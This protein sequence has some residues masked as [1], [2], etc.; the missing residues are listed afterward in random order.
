MSSFCLPVAFTKSQLQEMG[1]ATVYEYKGLKVEAGKDTEVQFTEHDMNGTEDFTTTAGMPYIVKFTS[2]GTFSAT[3]S[4][5]MSLSGTAGKSSDG[6]FN[7]NYGYITLRNADANNP[8]LFF[9]SGSGSNYGKFVP[10]FSDEEGTHM[11]SFRGYFDFSKYSSSAKKYIF[12]LIENNSSTTGINNVNSADKSNYGP[13]YTVNGQ[14][15]SKDGDYNLL[16]KGI[17]IQNNHKLVI[18]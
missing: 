12:S 8:T 18:K 6:V 15:V 7:G 16:P 1:I 17:Y 9:Y 11:K 10:A 3:Y 14:L 4:D 2:D 13:I 5:G